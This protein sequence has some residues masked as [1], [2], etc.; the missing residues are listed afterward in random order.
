MS[1]VEAFRTAAEQFNPDDGIDLAGMLIVALP[2]TIA[3]IGT[4]I[5]GVLTV[6]GQKA[7]RTRARK[8]D[9]KTDAIHEQTVNTHNTNMRDDLDEIRDTVKVI[10]AR[11][12]DQG[13]DIRG[14]RTDVGELRCE[15]RDARAAHDD[16]VRRLNAFIRREHP[17]ADP[18]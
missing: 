1:L 12:I 10:S 2:A 14:L 4:V 9:A 5:V 7:G 6:R 16:L 15:D 18:L 3:A 17:G 8:I 13:R 11:Q